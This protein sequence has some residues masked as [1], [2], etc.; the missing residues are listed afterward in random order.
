MKRKTAF[1]LIKAEKQ[2]R[3]NFFCFIRI[4][5]KKNQNVAKKKKC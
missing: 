5:E 1:V 4:A 2:K 3:L